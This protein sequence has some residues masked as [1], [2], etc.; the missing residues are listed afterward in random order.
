[1]RVYR[2][3]QLSPRLP[4]QA[5]LRSRWQNIA[6]KID[7]TI[8][9][10]ERS[11]APQKDE[12]TGYGLTPLGPYTPRPELDEGP[13]EVVLRVVDAD[14]KADAEVRTGIGGIESADDEV[15]AQLKAN[16]TFR[17]GMRRFVA[18]AVA[19]VGPFEDGDEAF[20]ITGGPDGVIS[21]EDLG[22]L[23]ACGLMLPLYQAALE[24]NTIT[25][26]KRGNFGGSPRST[27][28]TQTMT[29]TDAVNGIA[30]GRAAKARPL[31]RA[32]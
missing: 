2:P 11:G 20:D 10:R 14:T 28:A 1:M 31:P 3:G 12:A 27:S 29:A 26:E 23:E 30:A 9:E 8:K 15:E 5:C 22:I 13:M 32:S 16:K 18:R 7:E 17:D 6:D 4:L 21:D 24:Y 25:G 19:E